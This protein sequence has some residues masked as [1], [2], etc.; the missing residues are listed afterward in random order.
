MKEPETYFAGSV[1]EP[2]LGAPMIEV[3]VVLGSEVTPLVVMGIVVVGDW[4]RAVTGAASH[5]FG[6]GPTLAPPVF[7]KRLASNASVA[8][9]PDAALLP[10][11]A[12]ARP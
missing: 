9:C 3:G 2:A 12:E 8:D 7:P 10:L 1:K 6:E 4:A 5:V 11:G